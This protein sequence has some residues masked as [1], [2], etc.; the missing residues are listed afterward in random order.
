MDIKGFIGGKWTMRKTAVFLGLI[1]VVVLGMPAWAATTVDEY[2]VVF[3]FKA[4]AGAQTVT[5]A[6]TFNGWSTTAT[7]MEDPD[8]DGVWTVRLF[9]APGRHQ[10][11]FV[12]N[13]NKWYTDEEADAFAPDGFGGQNSVLNLG[14]VGPALNVEGELNNTLKFHPDGSVDS[15]N[16]VQLSISGK[17]TD[18]VRVFASCKFAKDFSL[19]EEMLMWQDLPLEASLTQASLQYGAKTGAFTAAYNLKADNSRDPYPLVQDFGQQGSRF[20]FK[21]EFERGL[22]RVN[23]HGGSL[24]G[25]LE[26][27][28][29]DRVTIGGIYGIQDIGKDGKLDYDTKLAYA[30]ARLAENIVLKGAIIRGT[31]PNKIPVKVT[32]DR[33]DLAG[34][35][36]V[37]RGSFNDWGE[38]GWFFGLKGEDIVMTE[39]TPG[40]FEATLLLAPGHYEYKFV[41]DS[42]P[43]GFPDFNIPLDVVGDPNLL[44]ISGNAGLVELS[45]VKDKL[46][47]AV[48]YK[49]A[50]SS[51]TTF[52][53]N[54]GNNLREIYSHTKYRIGDKTTLTLD[55]SESFAFDGTNR[56][57]SIKPGFEALNIAESISR[58]TGWLH[59]THTGLRSS[60][61]GTVAPWKNGSLTITVEGRGLSIDKTSFE[62]THNLNIM[63]GAT[64]GLTYDTVGKTPI[65]KFAT[66]F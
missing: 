64:L 26:Y 8:K 36:V 18:K 27:A 20:E 11:K 46:E 45:Y 3:S 9:L 40:Y 7:P 62:V 16:S 35:K 60:L 37:I 28:V 42:F 58:L 34:E 53:A 5:L 48:G 56:R 47:A 49:L 17:A 41:S 50:E 12:V 19:P 33:P 24:V 15:E 21:R 22:A 14:R 25:E 32:L 54:A 38:W 57:Y 59:F 30:S 43:N 39:T 23:V 65:A 55:A 44:S 10:Y 29:T 52:L 4:P 2:G 66:K 6:G 31:S 1:L 61:S 63:K 51:F 13:G